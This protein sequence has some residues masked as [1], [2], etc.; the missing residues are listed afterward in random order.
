M[1]V[2][3]LQIESYTPNLLSNKDNKLKYGEVITPLSLIEKIINLLPGEV[4]SNPKLAW[5]DPCVGSG[6]FMIFVYKKL[7][8]SLQKSRSNIFASSI[9]H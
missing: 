4:F 9:P 3:S 7:F 2:Y 8:Q 5:L 1:S 6:N